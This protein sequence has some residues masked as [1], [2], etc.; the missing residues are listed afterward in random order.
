MKNL[1]SKLDKCAGFTLVETLVA[2]SIFTM[3]LVA[4]MSLLGQGVADT[5][6]AKNKVTAEYLAQEGIEYTRY[7]RDTYVISQQNGWAEFYDIILDSEGGLGCADEDGCIFD[8][9][10]MTYI[11]CTS[12]WCQDVPLKYDSFSGNYHYA[13]GNNTIFSRQI[14]AESISGTTEE[15]K[16]TSTVSWRQG[17]STQHVSFSEI[18]FDWVE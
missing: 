2:I 10:V 5:N 11:P 8:P 14:K 4:V 3:S 12:A 7:M 16:I 1:F 18:L 17:S 6:F 13:S 15:V 9:A